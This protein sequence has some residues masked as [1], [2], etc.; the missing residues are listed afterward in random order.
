MV[1][2]AYEQPSHLTHP[3]ATPNNEPCTLAVSVAVSGRLRTSIPPT[4]IPSSSHLFASRSRAKT[5]GGVRQQQQLELVF[6]LGC[7]RECF[8]SKSRNACVS[9]YQR[10]PSSLC[11]QGAFLAGAL[12]VGLANPTPPLGRMPNNTARN[13]KVPQTTDGQVPLG[14][15]I[16]S[17]IA[18]LAPKWTTGPE[19]SDLQDT[20]AR[21]FE[22]YRA[23]R[24]SLRHARARV[25]VSGVCCRLPVVFFSRNLQCPQRGVVRQP[26]AWTTVPNLTN[27]HYFCH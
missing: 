11:S 18:L 5:S 22:Y 4:A 19:T 14:H 8:L 16:A 21:R 12:L 2:R 27:L 3:H 23:V 17:H 20:S 7:C 9:D 1:P 26:P 24:A 25:C 13:S 15:D 6:A 10:F